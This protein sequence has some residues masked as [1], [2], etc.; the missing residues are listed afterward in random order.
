MPISSKWLRFASRL[1]PRTVWPGAGWAGAGI[2]VAKN[3]TEGTFTGG[4]NPSVPVQ[5][6]PIAVS[7][8]AVPYIWSL[9][10]RDRLGKQHNINVNIDTWMRHQIGDLIYPPCFYKLS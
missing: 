10:V 4:W 2:V 5:L 7:S 9:Q 3:R 1:L 8:G 6:Q